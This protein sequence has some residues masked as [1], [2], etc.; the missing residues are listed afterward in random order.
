[1]L[2]PKI[3]CCWFLLSV[4]TDIA[5]LELLSATELNEGNLTPV[6]SHLL[7]EGDKTLCIEEIKGKNALEDVHTYAALKY[8]PHIPLPEA[9]TICSTLMTTTGAFHWWVFFNLLG[10]DGKQ[11]MAPYVFSE[12]GENGLETSFFVTVSERSKT[13][14]S[15]EIP[16]VFPHQWVKSCTAINTT[17]GLIQFVLDGVSVLTVNPE[18]IQGSSPT[19]TGNLILG[20]LNF[21]GHWYSVSNKV[22]NLNIFSTFLSEERMKNI[23][24]DGDCLHSGDYLSWDEM[25]WTLQGNAVVETV[26]EEEPCKGEPLFDL[27]YTPFP[28]MDSC[29]HHCQNLG[30][31]VPSVVTLEDWIVLRDFLKRELF[32]KRLNTYSLWL[33][34]VQ[35]EGVWV[36]FYNTSEAVQS[37][38]LQLLTIDSK[39]PHC[40]RQVSPDHWND[41]SCDSSEYACPCNRQPM[42]Y[43]KLRGL[44]LNSAV[45]THYRSRNDRKDIRKLKFVG[46]GTSIEFDDANKIWTLSVGG[47][48][49]TGTSKATHSSFMMGKHDWTVEG[50]TG[51]NG[52]QNYVTE[53]KMS[54]CSENQFT[55]NDG[56][57]VDIN[58]RCDQVSDCRDKSDEESCKIL[59]LD[60]G[61]KKRVP[62]M[63]SNQSKRDPAK[64][65]VGIRILKVVD[66][67]EENSFKEIQFRITLKWKEMRASY[68]NLKKDAFL[69][70]LS[71]KNLE[72]LWL[73]E[74]IYENTDQKDST[75][76]GKDWEWKT[77]VVVIREGNF[78]RGGLSMV[79]EVEIFEGRENNISMRQTYTRKFQCAM[80]LA[81]YPFDVQVNGKVVLL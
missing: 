24:G 9:F 69:N 49:V 18:E 35:Q 2:A 72:Q 21:G 6:V 66:I 74:V 81:R 55:C 19:L 42:S 62:P 15:I 26:E 48:N 3:L 38:T 12:D 51:C 40:A 80:E 76:I 34:I 17:S 31:R 36:D 7:C 71:E 39:D 23:T 54:G 25:D 78:S 52:G 20:A 60:A 27:Y 68:Y 53:L 37:S 13:P 57:C 44:C 46:L 47:S 75:R 41:K 22:T 65:F 33:S 16:Q 8:D 14:M 77:T 56:Q 59:L 67:D 32:D 28:S 11:L 43:L 4:N 73:P 30:S 1:M 58:L 45:D 50:D 63:S 29:M 61:Y 10:K 70:I 79:N 5:Q 64:V